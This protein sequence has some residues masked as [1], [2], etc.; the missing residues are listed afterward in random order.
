[1]VRIKRFIIIIIITIDDNTRAILQLQTWCRHSVP[2]F[3]TITFSKRPTRFGCLRL[4]SPPS[5]YSA[6]DEG[7]GGTCWHVPKC[8]QY[9]LLVSWPFQTFKTFSSCYEQDYS[10]LSL[11]QISLKW[12]EI[13][14]KCNSQ[15]HISQLIQLIQSIPT[16]NL[17][18]S[19]Q[20]QTIPKIVFRSFGR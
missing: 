18:V 5:Q 17:H 9:Y 15:F 10:T 6:H 20:S 13:W 3:P 19:P 1:M 2:T 12:K 16:F 11:F 14:S 8:A 4:A 7:L